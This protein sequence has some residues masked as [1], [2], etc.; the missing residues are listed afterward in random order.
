M[1][2][3][4][5]AKREINA[6]IVY[7]GPEGAGKATAMRY[8]YDRI[9]PSLRGDLKSI[10]GSGS[11][12]LFFNFRPFEQTLSGGYSLFLNIYTLHGKVTHPAA[13]KMTLKGADGVVMMGDAS[14][15]MLA[16]TKQSIL[17]L[18]D[19]LSGYGVALD[20]LPGVL[21]MNKA[22]LSESS[23]SGPIEQLT[24][25]LGIGEITGS[26]SNGKTGQ[27]VLEALTI[28][29]RQVIERISLRDDL[30]PLHGF[31][32]E[33]G[34]SHVHTAAGEVDAVASEPELL[35]DLPEIQTQISGKGEASSPVSAHDPQMTDVVRIT[36]AGAE[37]QH[38][39]GV[40]KI[41]LEIVT[42]QGSRTVVVTV[43][44]ELQ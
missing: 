22:D 38:E 7:F 16:A 24:V 31:T 29:S 26:F 34:K 20:D 28:L 4:N 41:P 8:V 9:R 35:E 40:V 6:K 36:V 42:A 3:V 23:T 37:V 27:G 15:G 13:W 33:S 30:K 32:V 11:D 44:A 43:S 1:A 18:K 17:Q 39:A 14:P 10:S 19:I 5:H 2:I 21:Q 12:L 25:S